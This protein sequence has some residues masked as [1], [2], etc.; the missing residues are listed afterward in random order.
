MTAETGGPG[1]RLTP[2]Q[3]RT[4]AELFTAGA[5]ERDVAD[6]LQCSAS[7]AHRLRERLAAA[8]GGE[9]EPETEADIQ[10]AERDAIGGEIIDALTAKRAELAEALTARQERAAASQA[11]IGSLDAERLELLAA[12]RDAAPLRSRRA[13]AVA[14]LADSCE[15]A[16]MIEA[17]IAEIDAQMAGYQAAQRGAE[18]QAAR[19]QARIE[20]EQLAPVAA[21]ELRGVVVGDVAA[22]EFVRVVRRLVEL[23]AK[24]GQS[25]DAGILPPPLLMP[26][27][28]WHRQVCG[29]WSAARAGQLADVHSAL[30]GLGGVWQDRDREQ[31]ARERADAEA[32][33]RQAREDATANMRRGHLRGG[34]MRLPEKPG[35]DAAMPPAHVFN[36]ANIH[37]QGGHSD[38][39]PAALTRLGEQVAAAAHAGE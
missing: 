31:L 8:P 27:D 17:S 20:G 16:G 11:A 36:Q 38:A 7:T 26:R 18:A 37:H 1:R 39:A 3:E 12:G 22:A 10:E 5:S 34:P 14:D 19:E 15:V 29:L 9:L 4:G 33:L 35:F 6:R 21:D 13:D 24:A 25:W 2:E 32:Q 28:A 23:E 30:A